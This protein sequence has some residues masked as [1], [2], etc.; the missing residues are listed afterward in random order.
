MATKKV[1]ETIMS[2]VMINFDL[3]FVLV[4]CNVDV[5]VFVEP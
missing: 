2:V 5:Y 1:H 4:N 3:A